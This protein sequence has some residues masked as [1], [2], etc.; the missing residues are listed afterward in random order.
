MTVHP[1]VEN[2]SNENEVRGMYT[3]LIQRLFV[4]TLLAKPFFAKSIKLSTLWMKQPIVSVR[5]IVW[6]FLQAHLGPCSWCP[7]RQNAFLI[8]LWGLGEQGCFDMFLPS[9]LLSNVFSISKDC[10]YLKT[11][12]LV[13][14]FK[15]ISYLFSL[16]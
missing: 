8:L 5:I 9:S 2:I 10:V 14:N 3:M 12:M 1:K 4:M 16:C 6:S 13:D 11:T 15:W 7:K